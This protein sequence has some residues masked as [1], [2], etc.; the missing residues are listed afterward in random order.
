[1]AVFSENVLIDDSVK[2]VKASDFWDTE[3][4]FFN[5]NY[6]EAEAILSSLSFKVSRAPKDLLAHWHRIYFCYQ[7][8]R[9]DQLYA[10][11]LDLLIILNNN[12]RSFSQRLIQGSRSQLDSTQISALKQASQSFQTIKGNRYSLFTTGIIG[13]TDLLI[14]TQIEQK[15]HD[16]LKL[17]EDFIQ[18]SQID[19]AM[20]ILELGLAEYPERQDLQIALLEIYKSTKNSERFRTQFETIKV[21]GVPLNNQWALLDDFFEG[22]ST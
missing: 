7:Q 1:M 20:T 17:A 12:G 21:C 19:E 11:L 10:A 2:D 16:Y 14:S 5:P 22:Q 15:Q 13:K 8:A 3:M 18:Y 6:Q 4:V 9:S